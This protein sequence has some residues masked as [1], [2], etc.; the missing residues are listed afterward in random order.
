MKAYYE[1][2]IKSY[3]RPYINHTRDIDRALETIC[4]LYEKLDDENA[5]KVVINV[6]SQKQYKCKIQIIHDIENNDLAYEFVQDLF[7]KTNL[8]A[9]YT[10]KYKLKFLK[11]KQTVGDI[12]Y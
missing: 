10:M 8:T 7:L 6:I 2:K 12:E 4:S 9:N 11:Q 3:F 1:L 5:D